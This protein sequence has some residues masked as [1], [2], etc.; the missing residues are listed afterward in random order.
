LKNPSAMLELLVIVFWIVVNTPHKEIAFVKKEFWKMFYEDQ[1][2]YGFDTPQWL[3]S[4]IDVKK[5][6]FIIIQGVE[7]CEKV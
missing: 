7:V 4:R 3:H 2:A 5:Q 1:K 6:K